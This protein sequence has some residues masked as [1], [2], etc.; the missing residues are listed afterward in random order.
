LKGREEVM[1]KR[2]TK[3]QDV[4]DD[5][6]DEREEIRDLISKF[7]EKLQCR[8]ALWNYLSDD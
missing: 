1:I 4:I 8:I 6:Q 3:L 5:I 7:D 2:V